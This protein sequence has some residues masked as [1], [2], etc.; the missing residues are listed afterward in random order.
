[1]IMPEKVLNRSAPS[2][3]TSTTQLYA[4]RRS[5]YFISDHYGMAA[6][7]KAFRR[8]EVPEP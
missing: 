1:M 6:A 3:G 4:K 5:H 7:T 8:T 2:A